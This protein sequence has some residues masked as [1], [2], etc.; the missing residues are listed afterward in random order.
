MKTDEQYMR[1]ALD[2]AEWA[3]KRGEVPVGAVIICKGEILS[4]AYNRPIK[5]NDPTAHAEILAIRKACRKIGNYRL[6]DVTLFTTLEPCVMCAGS[7]LHARINRVVYGT[8]DPK[9]G[10]LVSLHRLFDDQRFNHN[11][12]ITGGVLKY[13][14]QEILHRFF[15]GKRIISPS[16]LPV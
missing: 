12:E 3:Y 6:C 9:G 4:K 1:I 14:C 13:H 15:Q 5:M 2:Q 16:I 7:I 10:A 8:E 11:V